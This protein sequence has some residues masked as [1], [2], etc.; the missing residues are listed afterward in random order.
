MK[1]NIHRCENVG[2]VSSSLF[3]FN[4]SYFFFKF[5]YHIKFNPNLI[6]NK[7]TFYSIQPV[8]N[9][10]REEMNEIHSYIMFLTFTI[11]VQFFILFN[12]SNTILLNRRPYNLL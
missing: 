5:Y 1:N 2:R 11:L 10:R 12:Y 7:Q 8:M 6:Q 4:F 3:R 9:M